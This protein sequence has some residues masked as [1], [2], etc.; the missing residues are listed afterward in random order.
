[1]R[2]NDAQVDHQRAERDHA[3]VREQVYAAREGGRQAGYEHV[4]AGV[5]AVP[6]AGRRTEEDDPG[7]G[8]DRQL[9]S[10]GRRLPRDIAGEH[11]PAHRADDD[12]ER[13]AGDDLLETVE[14]AQRPGEGPGEAMGARRRLGIAPKLP[15]RSLAQRCV[16]SRFDPVRRVT[17]RRADPLHWARIFWMVPCS[18]GVHFG[19]AS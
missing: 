11:A 14:H 16:Q 18:P 8:Q 1:V 5:Q 4:D 19:K 12:Q 13:D 3:E 10:P 17:R 6:E 2:K 9:A 7:K 15:S